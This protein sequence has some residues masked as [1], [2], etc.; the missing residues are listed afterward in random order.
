MCT[1]TAARWGLG[2]GCDSTSQR[3]RDLAQD[4]HIP[5]WSGAWFWD[6]LA[7]FTTP[8]NRQ[9]HGHRTGEDYS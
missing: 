6:S 5:C 4:M 8:G 7:Q 2:S 3:C 9:H 1:A